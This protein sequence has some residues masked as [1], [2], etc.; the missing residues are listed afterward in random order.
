LFDRII[1]IFIYNSFIIVEERK[2]VLSIST[3]TAGY[4][5]G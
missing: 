5:T 3:C 1:F 2:C 4:T